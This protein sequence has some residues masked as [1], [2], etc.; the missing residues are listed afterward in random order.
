MRS[1][2]QKSES[3]KLLDIICHVDSK[4]DFITIDIIDYGEG[5]PKQNREKIFEPFYTTEST[6]TGLGLFISR[7]LCQLNQAHLQYIENSDIENPHFRLTIPT[8]HKE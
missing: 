1:G 8:D 6:G 3:H 4:N 2:I 7:E 5:I